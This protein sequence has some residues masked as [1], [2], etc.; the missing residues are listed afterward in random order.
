LPDVGYKCQFWTD[1][2]RIADCN[3]PMPQ[4]SEIYLLIKIVNHEFYEWFF[5]GIKPH[6]G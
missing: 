4:C 6:N 2:L 1:I 3:A 5:L